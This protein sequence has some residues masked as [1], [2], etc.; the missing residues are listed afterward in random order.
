MDPLTSSP[1]LNLLSAGTRWAAGNGSLALFV[2]WKDNWLAHHLTDGSSWGPWPSES[3]MDNSRFSV[4]YALS[5]SGLNVE[6]AGDIPE[7]LSRY[8]VVI[9]EAYWA[10]EP[11]HEPLFRNYVL[12]GGGVVLLGG[13]PTYFGGYCKDWWGYRLGLEDLNPIR[14]WFGAGFYH[15]A[16]GFANITVD[17]P[18]D[19]PMLKGDVIFEATFEEAGDNAAVTSLNDDAK[20]I[21]QWQNQRAE[22]RGTFALTHEYGQGRVYYQAAFPPILR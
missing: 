16:D 19:L 8:D 3:G 14:E 15:C 2:N 13:V 18:F 4:Y 7:N 21:A 17:N 9:V 1:S 22:R 10:V 6:F 11:K 20:I 5:Q 12:D